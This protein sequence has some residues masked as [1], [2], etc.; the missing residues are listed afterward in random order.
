M[1]KKILS[2]FLVLIMI[3]TMLPVWA[4]AEEAPAPIGA[5]GEIIAFASLAETEKSVTVGT[6]ARELVLPEY[7]TATVR[8][9]STTDSGAWE[10]TVADIPVTWTSVPE[11][12]M[13]TEGVY[14]FTPVIEGYTVST[15]LPEVSV[16]V[17][18]AAWKRRHGSGGCSAQC[19]PRNMNFG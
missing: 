1:S 15:A 10:E 18:A 4:M 9:A 7:L 14:L 11:Y 17:E 3:F 5:S 8:M 19:P 12:D 6:S 16:T 2:M 13:E